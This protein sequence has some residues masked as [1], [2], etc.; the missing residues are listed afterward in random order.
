MRACICER[1]NGGT[2]AHLG[3]I[4][5]MEAWLAFD[6]RKGRKCPEMNVTL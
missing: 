2:K 5:K 1:C 4:Q 3:L 6:T